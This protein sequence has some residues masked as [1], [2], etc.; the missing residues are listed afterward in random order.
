VSTTRKARFAAGNPDLAEQALRE[1]CEFLQTQSQTAVIATRAAELANVLYVLGRYDE[2]WD[3]AHVARESAGD[4]DLDAAL[5]RQPVEAKLHARLGRLDE[6]ERLARDAV[7]LAAPTDALNRQAEA[8][9]ALA[10]VLERADA[11][12]EAQSHR[13]AALELYARKGNAAAAAR[14]RPPHGEP[15]TGLSVPDVGRA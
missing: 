12:D 4:G 6:G 11:T 7:S 13:H 9:L 5:T 2:A 10:E 3:Y 15:Q 1:A 8:L 14:L